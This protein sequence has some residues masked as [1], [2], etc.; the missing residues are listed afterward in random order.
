[1]IE[2]LICRAL[3][4]HRPIGCFV[5]F[6]KSGALRVAEPRGLS[7]LAISF[8][9]SFFLCGYF[10]K[11]KSVINTN[12]LLIPRLFSRFSLTAEA[13]RKAMEKKRRAKGC[14]P[15]NRAATR[16]ATAFEKAAQNNQ[17][18]SANIVRAKSHFSALCIFKHCNGGSVLLKTKAPRFRCFVLFY[19]IFY[20]FLF[21]FLIFICDIFRPL[22]S[23]GIYK[24]SQRATRGAFDE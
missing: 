22:L 14:A 1:M 21:L 24:L 10:A 8:L 3:C 4:S 18:V 20:K 15:L 23:R 19:F 17:W 5:H 12:Y 13:Q 2:I 16:R 6:F 9:P 11:E 7:A